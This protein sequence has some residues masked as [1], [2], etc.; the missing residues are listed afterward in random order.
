MPWDGTYDFPVGLEPFLD[1]DP[2]L[3]PSS[4]H[5]SPPSQPSS[6]ANLRP[7][8]PGKT[9]ST[10]WT[11]AQ[12]LGEPTF[13]H[14]DESARRSELEALGSA[15][16]TVDNG[17]ENQWWNQ[18]E[19]GERRHLTA[20]HPPPAT[21]QEAQEQMA[22]GWV[23]ALL[24]PTSS[25][26]DNG[27]SPEGSLGPSLNNLIISPVSSYSGP[28]GNLSRSLS[29]RSDELWFKGGRHA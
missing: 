19:R 9:L 15:M 10:D 13:P 17:F 27:M 24:P 11:N 2:Y 20:V 5:A 22:L 4:S 14:G 8:S 7:Q 23:G 3:R 28:T 18:E 6:Q 12:S 29:T 1:L 25:V 26:D 16:M 21:R